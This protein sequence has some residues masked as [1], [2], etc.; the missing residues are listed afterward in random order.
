MDA[1]V[2]IDMIGIATASQKI[3]KDISRS[4]YTSHVG[5]Q[6]EKSKTARAA[7]QSVKNLHHHPTEQAM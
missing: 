4:D 3:S 2:S 6:F 7:S 5:S 1:V